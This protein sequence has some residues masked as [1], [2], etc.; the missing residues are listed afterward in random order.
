ML[1]LV[2]N[3]LDPLYEPYDT[4][5]EYGCYQLEQFRLA[6]TLKCN[7]RDQLLVRLFAHHIFLSWYEEL[8]WKDELP[9]I[10]LDDGCTS[11][12]SLVKKS[13]IVIFSFDTTGVVELLAN[14][15]P[16]ICFWRGGNSH[17][18]DNVKYYYKLLMEVGVIHDNPESAAQKV[19]EV[20]DDIDGWWGQNKVQDARK[21]FCLRYAKVSRNPVREL[22]Q[23]LS[24]QVMSHSKKKHDFSQNTRPDIR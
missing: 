12:M 11:F 20:W 2:E 10:Q 21:Q 8:R 5:N 13:R 23:I 19:N 14:N 15:F 4:T 24:Q 17:V 9:E 16:I 1:L 7:I 3:A 22:K 18:H 6:K